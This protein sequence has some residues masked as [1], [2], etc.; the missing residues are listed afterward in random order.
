MVACVLH[1]EAPGDLLAIPIATRLEE[2]I[3]SNLA[4]V[5]SLGHHGKRDIRNS[6]VHAPCSISQKAGLQVLRLRAKSE[7]ANHTQVIVELPGWIR[8]EGE[9]AFSLLSIEVDEARVAASDHHD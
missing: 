9:G 3:A 8:I 4:Y 7:R 2:K 5:P 6:G 1:L